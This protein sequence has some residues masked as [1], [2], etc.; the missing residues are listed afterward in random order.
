M[1]YV[2]LN[3][4]DINGNNI[5]NYHI[6]KSKIKDRHVLDAT[7]EIEITSKIPIC[8]NQNLSP[9]IKEFGLKRFQIIVKGKIKP[10]I[11]NNEE[12]G[13]YY[14]VACKPVKLERLK[15]YNS[16]YVDNEKELMI[17][18]AN[19]GKD[20]CGNCIY[21]VY[22]LTMINSNKRNKYEFTSTIIRYKF[23]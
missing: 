20:I 17:L 9:K 1:G 21:Q 18:A 8:S 16:Y 19:I 11:S 2:I 7:I 5:K 6:F 10:F 15:Y 13:F 23:N 14:Y 22:I 12:C 3:N 4:G